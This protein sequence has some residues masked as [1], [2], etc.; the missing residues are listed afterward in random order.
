MNSHQIKNPSR[1]LS[2]FN[3]KTSLIHAEGRLVQNVPTVLPFIL[4]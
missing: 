2:I 4:L 1:Y 3:S